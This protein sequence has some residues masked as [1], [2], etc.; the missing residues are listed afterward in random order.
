MQKIVGALA[1]A[2]R[3]VVGVGGA[4]GTGAAVN[5][6]VGMVEAPIL[7]RPYLTKMHRGELFA[8]MSA[9]MAGIAGTVM[10]IYGRIL[11]A[12][13]PDAFA[14]VLTAALISAPAAIA[15]AAILIPFPATQDPAGSQD[16]DASVVIEDPPRNAREAITRGTTDG[17]T[18]LANVLAHLIVLLALVALV[19]AALAAL[20]DVFGAPVTL[21]R[22]FALAFRPAA[23]LIGVD[24]ADID[25]AAR[26]LGT[27]TVLNEFVAYIDLASLPETML[28]AHSRLILLYALC[29]FANFGSVGVMVGGICAMA[30]A[31]KHDIVALGFRAMLAGTLASLMG[32]AV[33]GALT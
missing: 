23:W 32:G 19:N 3:R 1:F 20:P 10:V 25:T 17:V 14:Q 13:I 2:L 31:R 15:V 11:G 27:K 5:F 18:I 9:G 33:V 28:S 12:V 4:L 6:F 24:G 30:P 16:S 21:Q 22:L 7:I 26:L 8:L 29:G